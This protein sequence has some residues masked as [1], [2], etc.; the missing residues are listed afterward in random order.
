MIVPSSRLLFYVAGFGLPAATLAG[1]VPTLLWPCLGMMALLIL[2]VVADAFRAG[3]SCQDSEVT[4]P[5]KIRATLHSDSLIPI[6][7]GKTATREVSL[8]VG[9]RLDPGLGSSFEIVEATLPKD[10]LSLQM[11]WPIHPRKRGDFYIDQIFIGGTSPFGFWSYHR[12]LPVLCQIFVYPNLQA[13]RKQLAALFLNRGSIGLH[14]HRQMGQGREVEKLREYVPGDGF[15]T[16][17]WKATARRGQPITKVYQVER[18]QEIYVIIDTSRLSA[19]IA[20]QSA[21]AILERFLNAALL[22]GLAAQK[23]GDHFGVIAFSDRITRFLPAS[24][25]SA[26]ATSCREALYNLDSSMVSPD[27]DELTTFI[28]TRLRRRALLVFLTNLDDPLLGEHFL[29]SANLIK[30]KHLIFAP[31]LEQPGVMP[32]FQNSSIESM[33]SLYSALGNH[34]V[35]EKERELQNALRVAGVQ[36][37]TVHSDRLC[38]QMVSHYLNIKRRQLL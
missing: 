3:G 23:Q 20:P 10:V 28:R 31:I 17:H 2:V 8:R 4:F 15:D 16:I 18:T 32:F 35:W 11:C 26:H 9:L 6:I 27:F 25:G 37:S 33:P 13:D 7:L 22:L 14:S 19:R 29:R 1:T 38:T 34:L 30:R 12:S 21:E 5:D 36:T 24:H